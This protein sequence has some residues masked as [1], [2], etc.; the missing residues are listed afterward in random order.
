MQRNVRFRDPSAQ[1]CGLSASGFYTQNP[2]PST[3]RRALSICSRVFRKRHD[4]CVIDA[5]MSVVHFMGGG[6]PLPWWSFTPAR[7]KVKQ[8][9][10]KDFS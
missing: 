4:P 1:G 3:Q 5:F 2:E 9:S 10:S 8:S 6:D 7:K